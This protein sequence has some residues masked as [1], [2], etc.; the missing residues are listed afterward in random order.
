MDLRVVWSIEHQ[1]G[2]NN[3]CSNLHV[4][5]LGVRATVRSFTDLLVS[6]LVSHKSRHQSH[7]TSCTVTF[8]SSPFFYDY[9]YS[10]TQNM[11][12]KKDHH[13]SDKHVTKKF[14]HKIENSNLV[15][16]LKIAHCCSWKFCLKCDPNIVLQSGRVM[17][18]VGS[19]ASLMLAASPA[20][21]SPPCPP[22]APPPPPPVCGHQSN[23]DV[24]AYSNM[25]CLTEFN[26][27][28]INISHLTDQWI[29]NQSFMFQTTKGKCQ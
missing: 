9:L 7:S 14:Q 26:N 24:T 11:L 20:T 28:C 10:H 2:A 12:W 17:C 15:S 21:S 25:P 22:L 27:F 18:R 1:Y 16:I 19:V 4:C 6:T 3:L 23:C 5:Q 29:Y 8:N 13:E